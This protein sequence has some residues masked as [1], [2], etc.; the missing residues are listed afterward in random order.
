MK[1]VLWLG[2]S[3]GLYTKGFFNKEDAVKAI[4]AEAQKEHDTSPEQWGNYYSFSPSEITD[5]TVK[6]TWY[7]QHRQ[8]ESESIGD[9]NT[10]HE[11]GEPCGTNGRPTFAFFKI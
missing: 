8:C 5:E 3:M 7:Y 9:D 6:S 2:E 10:C 11:C 1:K 4:R